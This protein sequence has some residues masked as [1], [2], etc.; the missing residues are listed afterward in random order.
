M[1]NNKTNAEKVFGKE[2]PQQKTKRLEFEKLN[3]LSQLKRG[4][5]SAEK[6]NKGEGIDLISSYLIKFL[7]IKEKNI[8]NQRIAAEVERILDVKASSF[9]IREI[10][11]KIERKVYDTNSLKPLEAIDIKDISIDADD[12]G[13]RIEIVLEK[14]TICFKIIVC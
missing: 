8:S 9:L 5:E 1:E 11:S 13:I 3:K 14:V 6:T 2:T 12:E 10:L 4:F 7:K